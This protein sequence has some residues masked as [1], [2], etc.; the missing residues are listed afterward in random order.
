MGPSFSDPPHSVLDAVAC[1]GLHWHQIFEVDIS[2]I[3]GGGLVLTAAL[4]ASLLLVGARLVRVVRIMEHGTLRSQV[5]VVDGWRKRDRS[6]RPAILIDML[7]AEL[8]DL[9]RGHGRII[10]CALVQQDMV[11]GRARCSLDCRVRIQKEVE[12]LRMCDTCFEK[13]PRERIVVLVFVSVFGKESNVVPFGSHKDS[14][15]QLIASVHAPYELL[16][17]LDFLIDDH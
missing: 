6:S 1:I 8:V 14:E 12:H 11:M 5:G 13:G 7:I 3:T 9:V 17:V 2:W 4:R 15:G 16:D 10:G